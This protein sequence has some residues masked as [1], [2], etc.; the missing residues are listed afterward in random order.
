MYEMIV[1]PLQQ[2]IK[3]YNTEAGESY[4]G[5]TRYTTSLVVSELGLKEC[6]LHLVHGKLDQEIIESVFKWVKGKGYTRAQFEVPA[7]TKATSLA[8]YQY[9]KDGLDRYFV[10]L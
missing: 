3:F 10:E 7:G 1:E 6:R 9:T 2:V 4:R 5:K 8:T